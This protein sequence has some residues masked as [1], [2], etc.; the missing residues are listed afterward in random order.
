MNWFLTKQNRAINLDLVT[1]IQFHTEGG[2]TIY[3]P[4]ADEDGQL[5]FSIDTEDAQKLRQRMSRV[6]G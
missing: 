2:A 5:Q 1:D 6:L 4:V 3:K